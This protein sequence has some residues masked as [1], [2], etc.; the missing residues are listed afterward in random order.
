MTK[1]ELTRIYSLLE[2]NLD[3]G[4]VFGVHLH[5]NLALSFSLAQ[6]YLELRKYQRRS[7]WTLP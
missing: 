2:N 3:P 6:V 7:V 5:E 1:A 4:I